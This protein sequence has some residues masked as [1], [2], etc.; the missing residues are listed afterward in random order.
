[1]GKITSLAK[2]IEIQKAID[3]IYPEVERET[4]G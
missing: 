1:M 2:T 3:G 4:I